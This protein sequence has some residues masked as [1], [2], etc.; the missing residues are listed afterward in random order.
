M[1]LADH[2][3]ELE[4]LLLNPAIR[5]DRQRLESLLSADFVEFG[6][7]GSIW[8]RAKIIE[9]LASEE[10][11][12]IQLEDFRCTELSPDVALVTWRAIRQ[13]APPNTSPASLRSSIWRKE[14]GEWRVVFHQGTPSA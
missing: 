7:S 14:D 3:R 1:I 4:E 12:T 10:S 13:N 5:K 2:L 8:T 11:T 6:A 9:Q